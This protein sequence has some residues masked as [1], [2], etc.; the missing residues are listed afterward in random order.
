[1]TYVPGAGPLL[2]LPVPGM[3]EGLVPN[4]AEAGVLGVLPGVLGALQATEAIKLI[5]GVGEPLS[6]RLLMYDALDLALREFRFER[7][8]D[9]A[10]CGDRPTIVAPADPPSGLCDATTMQRAR[11]STATCGATGAG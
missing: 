5:V 2:P 10:V 7:R 11:A 3:P 8:R 4:C 1:M 9:C 6:G